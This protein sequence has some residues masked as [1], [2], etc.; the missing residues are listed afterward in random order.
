MERD[1]QKLLSCLEEDADLLN[2]ASY[3]HSIFAAFLNEIPAVYF[4]LME[5]LAELT[6]DTFPPVKEGAEPPELTANDLYLREM[7]LT[8]LAKVSEYYP[9]IEGKTVVRKEL[10]YFQDWFDSIK[11]AEIRRIKELYG[12]YYITLFPNTGENANLDGLRTKSL[13]LMEG[14][15]SGPFLEKVIEE[16]DREPP[17]LPNECFVLLTKHL[18]TITKYPN[19]VEWLLDRECS[20]V[21]VNDFKGNILSA[22]KG[23]QCDTDHFE[24]H[25]AGNRDELI[26]F[27]EQKTPRKIP[28]KAQQMVRDCLYIANQ[29]VVTS[30]LAVAY[31]L[32][33]DD[34]TKYRYNKDKAESYA[35][36]LKGTFKRAKKERVYK[37]CFQKQLAENRNLS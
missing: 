18:S 3:E 14:F 22:L 11:N 32:C 24:R 37:N 23:Y 15:A 36:N 12:N 34:I 30:N 29:G 26:R 21:A 2:F 13:S 25:V 20:V 19:F 17:K 6:R 31:E 16:D 33:E 7:L 35:S 10:E 27:S 4:D 9:G 8:V 5:L 1:L 28:R